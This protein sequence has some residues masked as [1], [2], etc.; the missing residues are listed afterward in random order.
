MREQM[1]ASAGALIDEA[2][3]W[4]QIDWNHARR[5]VR[6][7]QMRIAKAV[8]EG[9]WNKVRALQYLLSRSFYARLR[10]VNRVTSRVQAILGLI[11]YNSWGAPQWCPF[12]MLEPPDGK[13]SRSVLRREW[14]CKAPDLSGS[15][16][17]F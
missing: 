17:R 11:G 1:T 16:L 12:G 6:R 10:A 9:L 13:L 7:L 8:K 3:C 4:G 5:E 14:G 15:L 2:S